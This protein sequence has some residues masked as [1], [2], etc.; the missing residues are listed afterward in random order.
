MVKWKHYVSWTQL[1]PTKRCRTRQPPK[2]DLKSM[3]AVLHRR[4][5]KICVYDFIKFELYNNLY[6]WKEGAFNWLL[7]FS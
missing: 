4:V 6:N 3:A 2:E 5:Q 1:P 7:G